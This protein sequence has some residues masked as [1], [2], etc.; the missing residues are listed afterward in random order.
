MYD[1]QL[2]KQQ[3]T[4]VEEW[5]AKELLSIHTGRA[6]PTLLDGVTI[7]VYGAK[8]PI[9]HAASITTE[10]PRTLRVV[11]WDKDQ[12]KAMEKAIDTADLGV[13]VSVDQAGIRVFF[14]ELTSERRA[15]FVKAVGKKLEDARVSV[16]KE[17]EAVWEDIQ[18]KE[19]DREISE[20]DK[21]R[22]KDTLQELIDAKNKTLED[23]ASKKEHDIMS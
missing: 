17:R 13:S 2:L 3:L 19:K 23:M 16:R 4:G 20:D 22:L 7:D 14:P 21:Y 12:I 9:A 8:T 10:D 5:L 18:K 6:T 1:F 15:T 11:P